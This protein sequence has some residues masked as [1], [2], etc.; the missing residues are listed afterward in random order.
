M[1]GYVLQAIQN[2]IASENPQEPAEKK[3]PL[4]DMGPPHF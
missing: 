4:E 2:F 3:D 1:E